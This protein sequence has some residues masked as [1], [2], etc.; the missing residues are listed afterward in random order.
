MAMLLGT[1]IIMNLEK[2]CYEKNIWNRAYCCIF[3]YIYIYKYMQKHN[4]T[5]YTNF[6]EWTNTLLYKNISLTVYSQKGWCW[7]CMRDELETG[8][9]C[10][11]DPAVLLSHLGWVAQPWVTEGQKPSVC[12]WLSIRHLVSNW[13]Q[14]SVRLVILLF[15]A[16]L[17]LLFFH[18]F[19]QVHL[20]I[21]GSVEGQYVTIWSLFS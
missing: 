1:L 18:L 15:N 14:L 16:H 9:D 12:R 4:Q 20:L 2:M 13:L 5:W 10:Y 11:I 21:D 17:L 7:F 8:I 19:T 3:T 6:N